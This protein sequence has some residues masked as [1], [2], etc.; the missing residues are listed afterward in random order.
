M[1]NICRDLLTV[2]PLPPFYQA[3]LVYVS[4]G[5]QIYNQNELNFSAKSKLLYMKT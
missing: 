4:C 1:V 5:G 2:L 3:I